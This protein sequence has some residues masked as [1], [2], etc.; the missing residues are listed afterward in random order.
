MAKFSDLFGR[1][2]GEA[3]AFPSRSD[4]RRGN[5]DGDHINVENFPMS[6]R[7]LARKTRPCATC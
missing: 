4:T 6:A 5:G 3:G 2:G 1:K 7:A